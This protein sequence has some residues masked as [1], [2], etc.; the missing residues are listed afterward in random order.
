MKSNQRSAMTRLGA[1]LVAGV[2][3]FAVTAAPPLGVASEA[4]RGGPQPLLALNGA[5][6]I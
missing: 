4:V 5:Q 3:L 1:A 2:L 6:W